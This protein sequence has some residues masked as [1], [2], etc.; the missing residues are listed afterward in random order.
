MRQAVLAAVAAFFSVFA[1]IAYLAK[2]RY[3]QLPIYSEP[4]V[5]MTIWR[6]YAK[7]ADLWVIHTLLI[8]LP[9]LFVIFLS[10]ILIWDKVMADR[11]QA[12]A[13][14]GL[15]YLGALSMILA[16]KKQGIP[17]LISV[18]LLA[19]AY[20][21]YVKLDLKL[22][23]IKVR[24][25]PFLLGPVFLLFARFTYR[26]EENGSYQTIRLYASGRWKLLCILLCALMLALSGWRL[27][28]DT[29][30]EKKD[31][32]NAFT[33]LLRALP[34]LLPLSAL[35]SFT[36][37]QG[38]MS[39][40]YFHNGEVYLPMQQLADFGKLPYRDLIPI[41]GLCDYYY[42]FVDRLI[43]DGSYQSLAAAKTVGDLFLGMFYAAFLYLLI[44]RFE[45]PLRFLLIWLV[46]PFLLQAGM[47]YVFGFVL[48]FL[49]L[50]GERPGTLTFLYEWIL[51]SILAI[52]WNPSIGG[53][54]ALAL[55]PAAVYRGIFCLPGRLKEVAAEVKGGKKI[56]GALIAWIC[57]FVLG[58]A[59]IPMFL[60][61]V[62]YLKENMATTLFTNGMEMLTNPGDLA[63]A[64]AP[65]LTGGSGAF[66]VTVF[67]SLAVLALGLVLMTCHLISADRLVAF[68]LFYYV[69]AG[70]SFV[71]FDEGFRAGVVTSL[72]CLLLALIL[73]EKGGAKKIG[74]RFIICI[75]ALIAVVWICDTPPVYDREQ[76]LL[77]AD[78]PAKGT[79]TIM[80]QSVEDPTVY[81]SGESVDMEHLGTGFIS[82][83]ALENLKNINHV[84]GSQGCEWLDL[85]TAVAYQGIFKAPMQLPYTSAYNISN[86]RM[87]EKAVS[88]LG[89]KSPD[90]I[91]ISPGIEFD[92]APLSYR[93]LY[94]YQWILDQGYIPYCYQNVIYLL[95]SGVENKV[96]GSREGTKEFADAMHK[97]N[98]GM[99]PVT[100]ARSIDSEGF[101]DSLEETK[102]E[103]ATS[104]SDEGDLTVTF[105]DPVD[106]EDADFVLLTDEES[107]TAPEAVAAIVD[108]SEIE[109]GAAKDGYEL[110]LLSDPGQE[111][112]SDGEGALTGDEIS[113]RFDKGEK[114]LLPLC[115]S[116][117][118]TQNGK[119]SGFVIRGC[120]GRKLSVRLFR[121]R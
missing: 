7:D 43:F 21:L 102:A 74:P 68:W 111:S 49:L 30:K 75:T 91:L 52:A 17:W 76:N 99:L 27:Y 53:A 100:W 94:L 25:L 11:R 82:A 115:T 54:C 109:E 106:P 38:V 14:F 61:I 118:Y 8:G 84:I 103:Y 116:P 79:V 95:K 48:L 12:S 120:R 110:I 72:S 96:E 59:F 98:Q 19:G 105:K 56:T 39:I 22:D 5:G 9:L 29:R 81:A 71:R 41:H 69:I 24:F 67:G 20:F 4:V 108:T 6:G 65:A 88:L 26:Y 45:K 15:S 113:W 85:T 93:C 121:L 78:I 101:A 112:G 10:L 89:E 60:S 63:D 16:D 37:P 34:I 117:Y 83:N 18:I 73:T 114:M 77:G 50:S 97:K 104:V 107:E 46:L 92:E 2:D 31:D 87:Q 28:Y 36:L 58:L 62:S 47:R 80:G 66:F 32:E 1:Y 3:T 33:D 86:R 42:G 55:F 51:C 64:F 90:M 23:K 44:R 35:R 57:L 13:V 40:D 119:I 70:Y